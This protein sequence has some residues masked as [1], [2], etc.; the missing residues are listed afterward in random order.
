M[1]ERTATRLAVRVTPRAG[2]D[3]IEGFRE[4]VL[5]VRLAAPP[6]EGKANAALV[7]LLAAALSV[8]ARDVRVI[9]GGTT[10]DKLIAIDGLTDAD[11][12]TRLEGAGS[13]RTG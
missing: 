6:L 12:R 1:A 5:R 10:R 3:R 7:K 4:G 2:R 13:T 11:A 9:Q 8:P